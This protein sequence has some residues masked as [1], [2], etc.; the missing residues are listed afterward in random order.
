MI[1]FHVLANSINN[2]LNLFL[3]KIK[4]DYYCYNYGLLLYRSYTDIQIV[5]IIFVDDIN[6]TG[7]SSYKFTRSQSYSFILLVIYIVWYC[8]SYERQTLFI[9]TKHTNYK[10]LSLYIWLGF[11]I[12]QQ[13][14][15]YYF[16]KKIYGISLLTNKVQTKNF[17]R[18]FLILKT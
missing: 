1:F 14:N 10:A 5:A 16:E 2:Y 3:F 13:R 6:I 9:E 4:S 8:N 12:I 17:W 11:Y 7:L 18:R 15:K